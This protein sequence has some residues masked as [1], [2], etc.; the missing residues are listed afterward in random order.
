ML[1]ITYVVSVLKWLVISGN[2]ILF[3]NC[4]NCL[5]FQVKIPWHGRVYWLPKCYF[6]VAHLLII[7]VYLVMF[8]FTFWSVFWA[9]LWYL[10]S[11]LDH[12]ILFHWFLLWWYISPSFYYFKVMLCECPEGI[13]CTCILVICTQTY[14]LPSL[15]YFHFMSMF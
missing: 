11:Q 9:C 3:N 7:L 13:T 6:V 8:L 10:S 1:F 4:D 14:S 5:F 12:S 2:Y 15:L